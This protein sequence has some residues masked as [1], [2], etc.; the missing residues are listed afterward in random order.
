MIITTERLVL[1]QFTTDDAA[2]MLELLNSPGFIKY[3]GDR[4]VR[5]VAEAAKY[6]ENSALKS[7][8]DFGYGVWK[9][10]LKDKIPVGLCGLINRETLD[11]ID[12]GFAFLPKYERLGYGYEAAIA[13]LD[14][15]RSVL[16]LN[17]IVAFT[18]L[19]NIPSQN[20]LVKL[21]FTFE[22]IIK[23]QPLNADVKLF[24]LLLD[25]V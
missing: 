21:G 11:D 4:N 19:E 14:Y 16:K 17:R 22:R 8:N 9:V 7:Y 13:C 3:I 15:A 6:L 18:S 2:F 1:E 5:T 24:G 25:K 23:V 10:S 12:L 20:L